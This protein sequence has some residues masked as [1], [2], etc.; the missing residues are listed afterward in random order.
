M[1]GFRDKPAGDLRDFADSGIS[2]VR[3]N[4]NGICYDLKN[5]PYT[6]TRLGIV[7]RFSSPLHRKR[8]CD[9][10]TEREEWACDSL[11]RRF[12]CMIDARIFA[13]MQLYSKVET[14]GFSVYDSVR[15]VEY[16]SWQEVH[17][18]GVLSD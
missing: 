5:S 8:F 4:Q 7:Y 3:V 11:S 2:P 18:H 9:K 6:F 15:E 17:F 14:R 12:K 13:A 10:L 16:S 1:D